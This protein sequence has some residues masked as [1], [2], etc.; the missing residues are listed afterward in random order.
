M[1]I[2]VTGTYQ[3]MGTATIEV[4]GVTY[5][6]AWHLRSEYTMEL[7]ALV[8]FTRDYPAEANFWYVEGMGLVKEEHVDIETESVI[9]ARELTEMTWEEPPPVDEEEERHG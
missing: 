3:D 6:D 7:T 9:L 4:G 8:A 5:E 2:P 1:S